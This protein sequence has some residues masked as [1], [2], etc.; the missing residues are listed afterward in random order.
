MR[1]P[2]LT[3]YMLFLISIAAC[4]AGPAREPGSLPAII[5][6][7]DFQVFQRRTRTQGTVRI[8]VRFA[9]IGRTVEYRFTGEPPEGNLD[10]AWRRLQPADAGGREFKADAPA[11]AGGW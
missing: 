5:S 7:A 6:P 1:S 8:D 4:G 3:K 11:P 10:S 9:E 2:I